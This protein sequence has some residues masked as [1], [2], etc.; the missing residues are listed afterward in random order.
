MDEDMNTLRS[1][2]TYPGSHSDIIWT[3]NKTFWAHI[4]PGFGLAAGGAAWEGSYIW[5]PKEFTSSLETPACN[6]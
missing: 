3:S 2:V 5:A 6:K 4:I 1:H